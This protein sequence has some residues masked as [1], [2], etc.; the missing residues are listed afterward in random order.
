[1]TFNVMQGGGAR[2]PRIIDQIA[3]SN[4]TIVGLTEIRC[5]N[6]DRWIDG[7]T[8]LGYTHIEHSCPEAAGHDK[9]HSVLI[10]SRVPVQRVPLEAVEDPA[11]WVAVYAPS[12]DVDVLCVHIPGT[13]DDKV[14]PGTHSLLGV[15]RKQMMWEAVIGYVRPRKDK[16]LI[17]MGDFNTG[18]ND[19]DKT[20]DGT[21]YKCAEFIDQLDALGL[22]DTFRALHPTKREYTWYSR[23]KRSGRELNGFRLDHIF[24][25]TALSYGIVATDHVH[26]VRGL[27]AKGG[28]SD[29]AMVMAEL[30]LTVMALDLI[31]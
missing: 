3:Q 11:R 8:R 6:L 31:A 21:P 9:T 22:V 2:R 24:V 7:L 27:V 29:H 19:I 4:A 28:L 12:L 17:V 13:P 10:A 16:R 1:M 20:P 5:N 18:R 30:D 25:S 26:H 15:E 23:S 14:R